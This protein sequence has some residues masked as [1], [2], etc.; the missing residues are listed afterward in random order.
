MAF[1]AF[2]T[3]PGVKGES[4]DHAY[5]E[6]IRVLSWGWGLEMSGNAHAGPGAGAGKVAV[7]KLSFT[8]CVDSSSTALLLFACKGTHLKEAC[9]IVRK[10]GD[11]PLEYLRITLND[12]LVSNITT[13]GERRKVRLTEQVALNFAR[14]RMEYTP[15]SDAGGK[16]AT[17]TAAWDIPANKAVG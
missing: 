15:Q 6:G 10:A 16:G 12:V 13:G 3:I 11:V 17:S 7:D 9:L 1:D 5:P 14:F 4:R 8:K 2:L